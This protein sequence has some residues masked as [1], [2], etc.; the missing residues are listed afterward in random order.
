M[1]KMTKMD[2]Y[3]RLLDIVKDTD[4]KDK[5][6]LI[7][8]LVNQM[9]QLEH[10]AASA[11]ERAAKKRIEKAEKSPL[12]AVCDYLADGM[13]DLDTLLACFDD[14]DIT[15]SMLVGK[16]TSLVSQGIVEKEAIKVNGKKRM[17]YRLAT[18]T[19]AAE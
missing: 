10:M 13:K 15:K 16:L 18:T 2:V 4:C 6:D 17:G 14:A 19:A 11:K 5:N 12:N 8:F 7:D 3:A 1:K 9:N